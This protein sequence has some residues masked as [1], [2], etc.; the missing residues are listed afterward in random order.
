VAEGLGE[1][2]N[3]PLPLHVVFLGEQAEVVAQAEQTLEQRPSL[4]DATV[5]RERADEPKGTGEEL[6]F[7]ARQ[8]V[9][10]VGGRVARDEA[11]AAEFARNRVDG[12]A[13]ALV[14]AGE[15]PDERDVED[16]RV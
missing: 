9:V 13:D 4:V 16:A 8:P 3:L 14:V 12:A 10:G 1:V 11:V 15:E 7:V 2:A 6:P 5:E